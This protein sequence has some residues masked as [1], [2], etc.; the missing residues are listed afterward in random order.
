MEDKTNKPIEPVVDGTKQEE[1]ESTNWGDALEKGES[2]AKRIE[3]ANKK[4]EDILNRQQELA[5][6]N[7][8]GGNTVSTGEPQVQEE[9]PKEY[10]DRILRGGK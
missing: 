3:E 4:S 9:T 5:T 8:L 1:K 10:K 6:R 2:I 7:L